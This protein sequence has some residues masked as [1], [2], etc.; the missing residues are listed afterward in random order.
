MTR[1]RN[2]PTSRL[3][4]MPSATKNAER[5]VLLGRSSVLVVGNR[6][7]E[8]STRSLHE[9]RLD[10]A[11]DV[12][13]QYAGD[14]AHLFLRPVILHELVRVQNIAANLAAERDVLLHTANL[15][16]PGLL[17]FEPQIIQ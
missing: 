11:I 6:L 9:V 12:A 13:V 7:T 4:R 15:L 3:A 17:L 16:Q 1:W 2:K 14:V 10:E 5:P 8:R